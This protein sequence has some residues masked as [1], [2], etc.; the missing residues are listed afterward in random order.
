MRRSDCYLS[1]ISDLF[2][3]TGPSDN[4]K[5]GGGNFRPFISK[6]PFR[7]YASKKIQSSIFSTFGSCQDYLKTDLRKKIE[8]KVVK[9]V[10]F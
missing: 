6:L 2:A 9:Y 1:V 5:K 4:Q 3:L 10:M 8:K 7:N